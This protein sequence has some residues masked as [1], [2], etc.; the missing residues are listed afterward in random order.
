MRLEKISTTLLVALL[1][2]TSLPAQD[3]VSLTV[4]ATM[5]VYRAGGYNDGSNG[6]APVVFTFPA[7]AWQTMTFPSVG[8]AW[9]CQNGL[10]ENGADGIISGPCLAQGGP[11]NFSSIGPFSG[12]HLTDFQG[13][14]VGMFLADTLPVSPPAAL[15]FYASNNSDGGIQ[16]DFLALAPQIGQVFFIGDGLT[17]TGTGSIQ[18]FY[19]PDDATHLY[20]GYLDNCKAPNNTTPSCYSDNVGSLNVTARLQQYRLEWIKPSLIGLPPAR[21]SASMV[22]DP[23]MG[24]T[25]LYGGNTYNTLFGDTWA[26]SKTTG[27][28]QLAPAVSPPPLQ[29]A[30][31]AYDATTQT[32]VLFGGCLAHIGQSITCSNQTWTWDGV[33]WTE[34]FPPVSPAARNWNAPNGMVFDSQLGKVVM[35]GGLDNET[36]EWDGKSKTWTQQFPAHS[37][38]PRSATLAYDE[39]ANQVV[40]FG[41]D[42]TGY[43]LFGDTWTYDGVDWVQQQPVTSPEARADNGLAFDPILKRV[44]LFGGLAGPCEDCGETRLND[45][46]LWNGDNWIQLQTAFSPAPRSG[47]SFTYDGTTKGMLLFGGWGTDFSFTDTTWLFKFF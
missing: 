23:A 3:Q 27:W 22:Y 38:S 46:W 32:I 25:L 15:R 41:G 18:T 8:G 12:I 31:L 9:G 20:L 36:W 26:F 34:Q 35:F 43:Q 10:P 40:L 16:T 19:V 29:G 6:I 28:T 4:D 14:L 39:S 33:T 2:A 17:G 1:G 7:H 11:T 44:V 37:P 13:P 5:D 21:T 30:S 45:T 24:A 47:T 42:F